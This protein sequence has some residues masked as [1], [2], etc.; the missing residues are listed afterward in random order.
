M[1]SYKSRR[2]HRIMGFKNV[3]LLIIITNISIIL[4]QVLWTKS[5]SIDFQ[6]SNEIPVFLITIKG[7]DDRVQTVTY[8]FRTYANLNPELYYGING[9]KFFEHLKYIEAKYMASKN[10]LTTRKPLLSGERG[11]RETMR[12]IYTMAYKRN[13]SHVLTLEDDAIP[14]LNFTSLFRNLHPRCSQ[15]DVLLLG[16]AVWHNSPNLWPQGVCFDADHRTF[17]SVALFV[18]RSAFLPILSWLETGRR[19]PF[20]HM[21][22]DLQDMGIVVRVAH[23]PF[24]VLPE[25]THESTINNKRSRVQFNT[26]LRAQKHDWHFENHPPFAIPE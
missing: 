4:L 25:S 20:D 22:S 10:P 5:T 9:H 14:H 21:Y 18:K 17:G 26:K 8:L 23:P 1:T 2:L 11:L 24:L 16:A 15:A 6:S 13:Y 12:Q 3:F 7:H 19:V